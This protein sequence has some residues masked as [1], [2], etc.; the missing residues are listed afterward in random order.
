MIVSPT[1][2]AA[3]VML[4]QHV[5]GALPTW[6]PDGE[7]I[8]YTDEKGNW[9]IISPDGKNQ[10]SVGEPKTI[11][12]TFSQDS[13]L[14]YGIRVETDRCILYSIDIATKQEK[15]FGEFSADFAPAS[16]TN[17]GI[18]LSVAPDGKSIL[19][20]ARRTS[21]SLWMLEGYDQPGWLDELR[22][23]LPW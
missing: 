9:N 5:G 18:Q 20:P 10:R 4:R 13:K 16:P 8:S 7:W 6:S 17:P 22:E 1:G 3:P 11:Q 19:F 14:L 21:S 15:T 12:M 23:M 2:E